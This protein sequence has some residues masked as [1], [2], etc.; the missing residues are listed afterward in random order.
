MPITQADRSAAAAAL[1]DAAQRRS[2]ITPLRERYPAMDIDDAYAIQRAVTEAGLGEGRRIVGRKIGLTSLAV[3]KQLGVD[4]PDFGVLFADMGYGDG[5]VVDMSTLLQPK[6]EAE[7]A[8]V[9]ARPLPRADTTL[10]EV[11]DAVAYV[12]PALEIVDSRIADWNIR[13]TDTVADNASSACYVLGG[14]PKSLIDV[15]LRQCGMTLRRGDQ[16]VS[17]GN[18]QACL[19]NP[20]NAVVWLARALAGRGDPLQAGDIV[21]SGALGP[22][23]AIAAGDTFEARI[24]GLGAVAATFGPA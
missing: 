6:I 2:P 24:E 13:I 20:L 5:E 8:M 23:C 3:Q 22:M 1:I 12:L 11:I 15:D 16:V 9:L 14:S 19:G 18:G 10:A 7:V 17:Q 21:L 4:T